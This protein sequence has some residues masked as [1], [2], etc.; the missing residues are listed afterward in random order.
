MDNLVSGFDRTDRTDSPDVP[1]YL[2]AP[3]GLDYVFEE[4]RLQAVDPVRELLEQPRR[5]LLFEATQEELARAV[6]QDVAIE[7][8][9]QI[10]VSDPAL[11]SLVIVDR[12]DHVIDWADLLPTVL[13]TT[14]QNLL[15]GVDKLRPSLCIVSLAPD[16]LR[17]STLSDPVLA[18]TRFYA[19]TSTPNRVLKVHDLSNAVTLEGLQA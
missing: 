3:E 4:D 16:F 2:H 7:L 17:R 13:V 6:M 10:A 9:E 14:V 19:M 12:Q 18:A 11:D 8:A 15:D 1:D 5:V